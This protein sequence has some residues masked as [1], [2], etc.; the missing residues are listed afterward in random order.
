MVLLLLLGEPA[1][2]MVQEWH[3]RRKERSPLESRGLMTFYLL[4]LV[5]AGINW[6]KVPG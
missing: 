3:G 6:D 2:R 5:F 1:T 4:L